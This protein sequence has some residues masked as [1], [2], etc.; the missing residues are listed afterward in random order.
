MLDAIEK[1]GAAELPLD[2]AAKRALI[3]TELRKDAGRSD[4][5]IARIV[6]CDHKTVGT[7]RE[8]LGMA[9]PLGNS[10]GA[11]I[12]LAS[13]TDKAMA[14][15]ADLTKPAPPVVPE[16]D[17]F[18]PGSDALIVPPQPAIAVY[19]ND[20]GSISIRQ[21][22]DDYAEAD[23]IIVIRPEH[24]DK[25]IARLRKVAAEARE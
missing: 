4:R 21:P 17:P 20:A 7:A 12:S 2:M 18:E 3:E 13:A 9:S 14:M 25:L 5:E 23:L 22:A 11:D 1:P 8:R 15:I 16:W 24:V 6:G 19:A 10:P